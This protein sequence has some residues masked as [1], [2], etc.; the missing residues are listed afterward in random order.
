[1]D[2]RPRSGGGPSG[3]GHDQA[4]AGALL[5]LEVLHQRRHRFGGVGTCEQN[6]CG[7]RDVLEWKRQPSIDA[8]GAHRRRGRRRHAEASVVVDVG[9]A[10]PDPRELAEQVGL[11]VGQRAAAEHGNG[12]A[13][14]ARLQ[15]GEC[16]G[17]PAERRVPVG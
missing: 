13:P 10:E 15:S 16:L 7:A 14:V 2:L 3:I 4:A 6:Y 17:D 5:G 1:M 8:E 11:F 12:V 9:R